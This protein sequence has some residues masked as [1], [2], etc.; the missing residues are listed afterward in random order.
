M[1][2]RRLLALGAGV[3]ALVVVAAVASRG[4]PLAGS[5][6]GAGP[7]AGFFDYVF[8]TTAILGVIVVAV[9]VWGLAGARRDR[10]WKR[11]SR[12]H[13]LSYFLAVAA[14]AAIA[15][16]LLHNSRFMQ[17]LRAA[18]QQANRP[19]SS[20]PGA[21]PGKIPASTRGA[22]LRWDEVA[23]V[24]ALLAG[25]AGLAYAGRT[26][27]PSRQTP[28]WRRRRQEAVSVALDESLD[29]L[30]KEPDLR[31]AIIA[32]YARMETA[33]GDAGITRHPA[34]APLEYMERAL[35]S[36]DTSTAAVRRLTVL[37]EWAKFSQHEPEPQ[38]R[39]EAIDALVTVRD[40]LRGPA[41]AVAA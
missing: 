29:D 4:R 22:H 12:N 32:A 34:E 1:E 11:P 24:A 38:M 28:S 21:R 18:A 33:L 5:G 6:A 35:T 20:Q 7:T 9:V 41:E 26:R 13:L 17:R 15:T 25:A 30:R 10:T 39:D 36:L 23:V 2:P 40:E 37:F 8:T 3:T 31:R 27:V 16:L 14:G 19:Q